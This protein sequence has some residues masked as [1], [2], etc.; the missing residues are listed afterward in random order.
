MPDRRKQAEKPVKKASL[1]KQLR[2]LAK[3]AKRLDA[4]I[5]DLTRTLER[6]HYR[7]L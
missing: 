5:R 6:G 7:M 3:E 1:K 4:N 2:L